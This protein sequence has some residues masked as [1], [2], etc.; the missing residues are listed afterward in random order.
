[1]IA[2]IVLLAV[3]V[4][5]FAA[6]ILLRKKLAKQWMASLMAGG[7]L[8]GISG[9]FLTAGQVEQDR[10]NRENLYTSLCYLE[11]YDT[12]AALFYAEKAGA[13]TYAGAAARSLLERMRENDLMARLYADIAVSEARTEEQKDLLVTLQA[14]DIHQR[15]QVG[16][17]LQALTAELK[18]SEESKADVEAFVDAESGGY[19]EGL[20]GRLDETAL[21]R[22][23]VGGMLNQGN[24]SGAVREAALLADADPSADNRLLLAEAVAESAYEGVTLSAEIFAPAD[25][26]EAEKSAQKERDKLAIEIIDLQSKLQKLEI[27]AN[28]ANEEQLKSINQEKLD[29]TERIKALTARSDKLF[30]YRAF[31]AIADIRSL[32]AELVRARLHFALEDQ[33]TAVATLL[34]AAGSLGARLTSDISLGN[35]LRIVKEAYGT[36][37]P[38][39]DNQE[40]RDAVTKLLAAPFADLVHVRQSALTVDF[41]EKVVSDQKVYGE[42]LFVSGMDTRDYPT[43]RVTLSGREEILQKVVAGDESIVARDTRKDVVYTAKV[44]EQALTSISVVV[45]ASGSMNG[46]PMASL[47]EALV[48][49]V[50]NADGDMEIS[51]S[52]FES[53]ARKLTD[54]TKDKSLLLTE[55]NALGGGGGTNITS[56]IVVGTETLTNAAGMRYMLL[57]TDGQ[58]SINFDT[59]DA[60]AAQGITIHTIGFGSVND[61]L[62]EE[63]ARRTG[64]Q[65]VK[66]DSVSELGNVYASL[67]QLLG[68]TVTVEYTVENDGEDQ[69]YFFLQMGDYSLRRDYTV[70]A[71]TV[72]TKL[73]TCSPAIVTEQE[74]QRYK[75]RNTML[76]LTFTGRDLSRVTAVT[77][78]GQTATVSNQ[79]SESLWVTVSPELTAGWQSVVL[80]LEDG[81]TR[82]YDRLLAVG[83][84]K[85]YRNV[86]LG[87]ITVQMANGFLPGDGTLVLTGGDVRLGGTD[88][89]GAVLSMTMDGTLVLPW[90]VPDP[91]EGETLPTAD[92]DL[93]ESGGIEGWGRLSLRSDDSAYDRNVSAVLAAGG[94]RMECESGQ[95]K[96]V[97]AT[98]GGEQK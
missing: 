21:S 2:A 31:S 26:V 94:F 66:A 41:M 19:T 81:T 51:L 17:V 49:F 54:L 23:R 56:G 22:L 18:L 71:D 61:S 72:T 35:A 25:A 59:V 12:D 38:R 57:M 30:V 80:Q 74:L 53:S 1:M 62:L 64:G 13:E 36:E 90:T 6:P 40:F 16:V 37:N 11:R 63:I 76:E 34:E 98:E 10:E 7:M 93:G 9:G 85:V 55:V 68:N 5:L 83:E 3:G 89:N 67:Q 75:D 91:A 60:A 29:L 77:V 52:A 50:Q 39:L 78:G 43:V 84:K 4:V 24:Y 96:L 70:G 73:L 82:T 42:S 14:A 20:A 95:C 87:C 97:A 65:Y 47:K 44:T 79:Q 27:N 33:E 45:D 32:E 8:L 86:R 48:A 58:S 15:E 28:G 46:R 92:I 69:R 88:T